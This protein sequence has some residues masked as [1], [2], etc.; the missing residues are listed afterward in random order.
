MWVSKFFNWWEAWSDWRRTGYPQLVAFTSD[1]GNVTG[2]TIPVRLQYLA[3]EVA[4]NPNFDQAS[5][6]NYTSPLWWDGGQE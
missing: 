3:T 1:E 5:H 2:G 4:S 6:N